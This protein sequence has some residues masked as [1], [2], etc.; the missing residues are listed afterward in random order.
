M[1]EQAGRSRLCVVGVAVGLLLAASPQQILRAQSH[2]CRPASDRAE[3]LIRFVRG[4]ASATDSV[5]AAGR[6]LWHIP[7]MTPDS[8][9][10]V[11]RES[12]CRRAARVYEQYVPKH[13]RHVAR[14]VWVIKAGNVFIVSDPTVHI[15]EWGLT[16]VLDSSFR[17]L[18]SFL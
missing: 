13:K 16:L 5:G 14:R 8:I 2:S 3:N 4:L 12:V 1:K 9:V 11:D 10:F 15:G 6:V 17:Y 7:A 18:R